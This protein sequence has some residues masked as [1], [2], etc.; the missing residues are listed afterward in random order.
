MIMYVNDSFLFNARRLIIIIP[1]VHA[2]TP[3]NALQ[4]VHEYSIAPP[5]PSILTNNAEEVRHPC[6]SKETF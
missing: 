4:V 2:C 1:G 6:V 3:G 5:L